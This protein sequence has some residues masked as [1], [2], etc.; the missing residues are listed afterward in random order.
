VVDYNLG[1]IHRATD[2]PL[3]P[4]DIPPEVLAAVVESM[5]RW[6]ESLA[7]TIGPAIDAIRVLR[8]LLD[9][10]NQ[11]FAVVAET[12][13][14]IYARM[15]QNW[16]PPANGEDLD[17]F[18]TVLHEGIPLAYIP[19]RATVSELLEAPNYESRVKV[20]VNRNAEII[21]DCHVALDAHHSLHADVANLKPLLQE[22]LSVLN[23]GH[24]AS[25]QALAVCVSDTLLHRTLQTRRYR[26]IIKR[27]ESADLDDAFYTGVYRFEL[28]LRPVI[29]FLDDWDSLSGDLPPD[30]LSR[31]ATVH[32]ASPEHLSGGNATIAVMLATSLLLG[33]SEWHQVSERAT[34]T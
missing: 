8:P 17:E 21:A 30:R 25:A 23:L 3:K 24:H 26:K 1:R 34:V 15:P 11:A 9:T 14:P 10:Y 5:D 12:L 7:A 13:A 16:P 32:G 2:R 19:E 29:S 22:A 28:A 31:T 4:E 20:L 27:I 6:R 33:V 18:L